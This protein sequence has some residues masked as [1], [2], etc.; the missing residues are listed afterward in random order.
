M[1]VDVH[2]LA[3]PFLSPIP[4]PFLEPGRSI[5]ASVGT[6]QLGAGISTPP[7]SSRVWVPGSTETYQ[8]FRGEEDLW[9]MLIRKAK[10]G[11]EKM[12]TAREREHI[13][14]RG[15]AKVWQLLK[16]VT[17]YLSLYPSLL[18]CNKSEQN[19]QKI[20]ISHHIQ[21][22]YF[23]SPAHSSSVFLLIISEARGIISIFFSLTH[24]SLLPLTPSGKGIAE[25]KKN[26]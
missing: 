8:K 3:H 14:K 1:P 6:L 24:L 19:K 17:L 9:A 11:W 13:H 7:W 16:I 25:Q 20:F 2:L 18:L 5:I 4:Y 23:F 12:N 21:R 10:R 22:F 26:K 15:G